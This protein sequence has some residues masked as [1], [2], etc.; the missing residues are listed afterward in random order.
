MGISPWLAE[1]KEDEEEEKLSAHY[2]ELTRTCIKN[3]VSP[4]SAD[5]LNFEDGM[6][7]LVDAA[8]MAQGILRAFHE[9]FNPLDTETK[10]NLA[11]CMRATRTRKPFRSNWLLFGAMPEVLLR[12]MGEKD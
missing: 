7:P 12:K 11:A 4:S 2:A 9:L 8:F 5:K 10:K 6:Q 3:A 1:K